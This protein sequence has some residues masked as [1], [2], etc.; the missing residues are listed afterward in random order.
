MHVFPLV[1]VQY[2][3]LVQ[4]ELLRQSLLLEQVTTSGGG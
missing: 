4:A 1:S 3:L 2:A